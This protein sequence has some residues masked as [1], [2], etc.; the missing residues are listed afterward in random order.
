MKRYLLV[1]GLIAGLIMSF[2]LTQCIS[3]MEADN[4]FPLKASVTDNPTYRD[5]VLKTRII[6]IGDWN[7]KEYSTKGVAH[8]LGDEYKKVRAVNVIIRDDTDVGYCEIGRVTYDRFGHGGIKAA[9]A[10]WIDDN[11]VTLVC[12][13]D[14]N[15]SHD[16][17][18]KTDFNR[19]WIAI[20]YE[21]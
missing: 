9:S 18:S 20:F 19:G 8:F 7:M 3:N 16:G 15:F 12:I 11:H 17:F 21:E 5:V 4:D 2:V 1:M 6:E 14:S 10:Q 13:M